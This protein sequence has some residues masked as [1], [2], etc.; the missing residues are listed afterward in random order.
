MNLKDFKAYIDSL[1]ELCSLKKLDPENVPVKI[2]MVNAA[3]N[4]PITIEF[5]NVVFKNNEICIM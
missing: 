4:Q 1:D 3:S 5:N 2:L